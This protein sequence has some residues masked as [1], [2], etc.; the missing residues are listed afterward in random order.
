MKAKQEFVLG[1]SEP[2]FD[3]C[4]VLNDKPSTV[5]LDSRSLPLQTAA[6]FHHPLTNLHLEVQTTEPAF[7]FYTGK[8]IDTPAVGEAPA[9]ASR[10]GFAVEPARYTNAIN[11]DQ[12]RGMVLLRRGEAYGSRMVYTAFK[13]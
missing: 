1:Q 7:Q 8:Y 2:D 11:V 6:S 4:F 9:R 5:P 13:T 12:W 3:N 10:A